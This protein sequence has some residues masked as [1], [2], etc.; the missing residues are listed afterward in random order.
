LE[1]GGFFRETGFRWQGFRE[2]FHEGWFPYR[3]FS[4]GFPSRYP[5]RN[6]G[7]DLR[8]VVVFEEVADFRVAG[9]F[10]VDGGFGFFWGS[11]Y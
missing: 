4:S 6:S 5:V 10:R 9:S 2:R 11:D 1:G 8:G 3:V 7:E